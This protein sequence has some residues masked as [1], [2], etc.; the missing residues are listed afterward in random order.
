MLRVVFGNFRRKTWGVRHE[1]FED[2]KTSRFNERATKISYSSICWN[3]HLILLALSFHLRIRYQ[4]IKIVVWVVFIPSFSLSPFLEGPE[5]GW[6]EKRELQVRGVIRDVYML[7]DKW[8]NSQKLTFFK[9][10]YFLYLAKKNLFFVDFIT[11]H[12]TFILHE[13]SFNLLRI[14]WTF[15]W[16]S[17][18]C[19]ISK[20]KITLKSYNPQLVS[21]SQA[22]S[23]SAIACIFHVQLFEFQH[24]PF[25]LIITF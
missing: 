7:M 18:C 25:R 1:N 12:H 5:R 14:I 4:R 15:F 22:C 2:S 13:A 17:D 19:P 10:F 3:Q 23:T 9:I 20:S 16:I 24:L 11:F 8:R 21:V 6:A